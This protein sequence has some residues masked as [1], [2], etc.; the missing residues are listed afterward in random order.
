MQTQQRRWTERLE[1]FSKA[2]ATLERAFAI[3][4]ER[5]AELSELERDGAI[6]R[7]E[8]TVELA[9]KTLQDL[10]A[11]RG[12]AEVKG[13]KIVLK[14]AFQDGIIADGHRWIQM[15]DSRNESTHLYDEERSEQIFHAIATEY[16]QLLRAL[17]E[18]LRAQAIIPS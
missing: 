11:E 13:P 9:W 5:H 15:I 14:Q 17:R 4:D 1:Q 2:L 16:I 12:Y 3:A 7:F 18:H 10:L 6:Q 8:F